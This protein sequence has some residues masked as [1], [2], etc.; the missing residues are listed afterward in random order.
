MKDYNYIEKFPLGWRNYLK[1]ELHNAVLER[2]Q[3]SAHKNTI[4][5]KINDNTR[6]HE[7]IN[8]EL[9][10]LKR[11][12]EKLSQATSDRHSREIELKISNLSEKREKIESDITEL[13]L[14]LD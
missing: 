5:N 4:E 3:S 14:I 13:E 2:S 9:T 8:N 1:D 12:S 6:K 10:N 11:S 7:T